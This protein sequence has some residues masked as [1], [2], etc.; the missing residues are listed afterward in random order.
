M[1]QGLALGRFHLEAKPI[2]D[3]K[4]HHTC[5]CDPCEDNLTALVNTG[6]ITDLREDHTCGCD[7]CAYNQKA[8]APYSQALVADIGKE[9]LLAQIGHKTP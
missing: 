5:E 7:P 4:D 1:P 9:A 2:V 3:M 6:V 8:I